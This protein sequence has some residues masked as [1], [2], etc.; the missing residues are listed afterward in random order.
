MILFASINTCLL[1]NL[2]VP[3][4][5]A[6]K[7]CASQWVFMLS[8]IAN[9]KAAILFLYCTRTHWKPLLVG[10]PS[11]LQTGS[12]SSPTAHRAQ[13]RPCWCIGV[14]GQSC[15]WW[16]YHQKGSSTKGQS[17][18]YFRTC[19]DVCVT[20]PTLRFGTASRRNGGEFCWLDLSLYV[21]TDICRTWSTALFCVTLLVLFAHARQHNLVLSV[22]MRIWTVKW[23]TVAQWSLHEIHY[24]T[25]GNGTSM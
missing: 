7:L 23:R 1:F 3:T 15:Q 17:W 2:F 24:F 11:T 10:F 20:M 4:P 14:W 25:R 22:E 9:D 12:T 8:A 13:H 16:Q 5:E 6:S 18:R 19:P 21:S